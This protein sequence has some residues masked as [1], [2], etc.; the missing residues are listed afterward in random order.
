MQ[1]TIRLIAAVA[2]LVSSLFVG[3]PR[4][5]QAAGRY[6]DVDLSTLTATAYSGGEAVFSAPV[7]AGRAGFETPTGTFFIQ[8]R[9]FSE[10]MDSSTIGIPRNAPGGYYL[11]GVLYTQYF[12]GD[13][14]ALHANYWAAPGV[15]GNRN[16]SHGCVGM[17][18]ADAAAFWEF[19]DYGTEVD[20]H[21]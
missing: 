18:T 16:T 21:Y 1:R 19:A 10:T 13:G 3:A 17:S 2:L 7:T 11:T 8:R 6:I 20:V 5:A 14:V 15:F 4:S 12:T 9:V